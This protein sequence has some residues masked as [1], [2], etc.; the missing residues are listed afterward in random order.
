LFGIVLLALCLSACGDDG[1]VSTPVTV[2][3]SERTWVDA[4]RHTP[5]TSAYEGAATR[6]LRTRL[7]TPSGRDALPLLIMAHGFGG[8]PEKFEAFAAA[9]AKAGYVVAAPAFPLT[10]ENAPGG[11]DPGFRDFLNQPGDVSFV[12]T[13]LLD[14]TAGSS[15]P[16]YRRIDVNDVAVLGH[17]LGGVT[18]L[19]LTRKDCCRDARLRASILV[20]AVTSLSGSFGADPIAAGPPTL[21]LHGTADPIVPYTGATVLYD[22]IIA[23]RFLVGLSNASHSEALESQIEPPIAARDAAQRA[24]I[25]F[26]DVLF[27]G[28]SAGWRALR[29]ELASAGNVVEADPQ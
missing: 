22:S 21:I 3:T 14:A 20:A 26:L 19:A 6:T 2:M 7:W 23:P 11:H 16:L 28:D 8:S 27:R 12:I 18:T 29:N 24:T 25:A 13:Q 1:E 17:S 10:N 4:T 9:V 15:D 5:R